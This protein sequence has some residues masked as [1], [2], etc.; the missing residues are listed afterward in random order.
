MSAR[1][2]GC[3]RVRSSEGIVAVVLRAAV[4]S[5]APPRATAIVASPPVGDAVRHGRHRR[6]EDSTGPGDGPAGM[7]NG[8]RQMPARNTARRGGRR[9]SRRRQIVYG[10]RAAGTPGK[11]LRQRRRGHM[12]QAS[13]LRKP[14]PG[15][16]SCAFRL[17]FGK[18]EAPFIVEG[19][20]KQDL[21]GPT[22]RRLT[23]SGPERKGCG[24]ERKSRWNLGVS[25][26][27]GRAVQLGPGRTAYATIAPR[28]GAGQTGNATGAAES[29]GSQ[30]GGRRVAAGD[31]PGAG[32]TRPGVGSGR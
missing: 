7:V 16:V 6:S 15:A 17:T 29:A 18:P 11:R 21:C 2:S 8:Q 14:E 5:V 20:K 9:A 10:Q 1:G 3:S 24:H 31:A 13:W 25:G 26:P 27:L 28:A 12:G 22:G 32:N 23:R 30:R 4:R 19:P